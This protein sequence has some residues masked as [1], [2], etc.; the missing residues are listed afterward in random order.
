MK[1]REMTSKKE[2]TMDIAYG[3]QQVDHYPFYI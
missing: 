1:K 3:M 2:N